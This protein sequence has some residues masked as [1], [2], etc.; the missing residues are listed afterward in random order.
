MA[1]NGLSDLMQRMRIYEFNRDECL[2]AM[3]GQQIPKALGL[4]LSRLCTIRGI[5]YHPDFGHE[6]RGVS[7]EFTRALNAQ[8][9]I[10]N[11]IPDL[12]LSHP[13]EIPYC[14][15][16]P[17]TASEATYRELVRRYP[18]M[19]YQVGRSCAVAG[20]I[21]LYRELD[22][23][24]EVHIA[25]EA[26]ECGQMT[27]F[28]EIMA[29]LVRY[30]VMNDYTRSIQS[31]SPP[32]ANLNGDTAPCWSLD[33][34]QEL[35]HATPSFEVFSDDKDEDVFYPFGDGV[36][37]NTFNITEDMNIDEYCATVRQRYD[38]TPLLSAPLPID[39]PTVEKDL[40]ILMAAYYGDI[41]RYARLRREELLRA[42]LY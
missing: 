12:Q 14:I 36:D 35:T 31:D 13:E 3:R 32:T 27:L 41:D 20:Y 37:K 33:I 7:P 5:R 24:P 9:I 15:W 23:L 18:Y 38:I 11:L 25:E 6:L 17:R 10:N 29:A 19:A 40:L 22:I 26:R 39:L 42:E 2:A 34:K 1:S 21:D 28:N 16:Y 8:S 4:Q 30:N